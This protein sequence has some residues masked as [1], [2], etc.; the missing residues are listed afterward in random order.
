MSVSIG[1]RV[2]NE[3]VGG[4]GSYGARGGERVM[5]GKLVVIIYCSFMSL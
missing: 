5:E 3:F 1:L 2:F 4:E